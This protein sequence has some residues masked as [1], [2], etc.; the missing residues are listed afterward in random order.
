MRL[1]LY[2]LMNVRPDVLD[3]IH[4]PAEVDRDTLVNMLYL[5]SWDLELVY[6]FPDFMKEMVGSWSAAHLWQWQKL[7]NTTKLDYNPIWNKDG[8]ITETE[9]RETKGKTS[10][11]SR[12][13]TT[14]ESV[15]MTNAFNGGAFQ[16]REKATGT[17]G[18]VRADSGKST[19]SEDIVRT[20]EEHG[21]IGVTSTQQM[22]KEEREI[23]D[24][25]IYETIAQQFV[26]AFCIQVY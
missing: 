3:E 25:S 5:K 2:G 14:S 6:P 20:R 17:D 11:S 12:S 8:V 21:N 26:Q 16:D 15:G 18:T 23:S 22:I 10:S 13:D 19:G 9:K 1:S 4:L 7:V 24:F